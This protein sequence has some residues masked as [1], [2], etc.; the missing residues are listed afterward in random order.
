M[1][2]LPSPIGVVSKR[3]GLSTHVIRVWERR[4]GVIQ[5]DRSAGNRRHYSAAEIERL[6]LLKQV[7]DCGYPIGQVAH[8]AD[9]DLKRLLVPAE[10][11][12]TPPPLGRKTGADPHEVITVCQGLLDEMHSQ[13]LEAALLAAYRDFGLMLFLQQL[14]TPLLRWAGERW[15]SG[16]LRPGQEHLLTVALRAILSEIFSGFASDVNAPVMVLGTLPGQWH[17]LGALIAAVV[18]ASEGWRV[19]YLGPNLPV[20][21]I[22]HSAQTAAATAVGISLIGPQEREQVLRAV[23]LLRRLLPSSVALYAGGESSRG[24]QDDLLA[25]GATPVLDLREWQTQC[26]LPSA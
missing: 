15:E 26:Q 16:D 4:Y 20:D 14:A 5:P 11:H 24:M 8:L 2:E 23:R 12:E 3:T 22:A 1:D 6:R 19:E 17:E 18:A 9:N 7:T 21:E 10:A 13:K 25:L